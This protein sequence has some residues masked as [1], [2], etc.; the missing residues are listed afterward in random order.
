MLKSG[1]A[2]S[3]CGRQCR[4]PG[5]AALAGLPG[6]PS[7]PLRGRGQACLNRAGMGGGQARSACGRQCR[8][9]GDAALAGL[10]GPLPCWCGRASPERQAMCLGRKCPEPIVAIA[11]LPPYSALMLAMC[12]M[13]GNSSAC[14]R[15]SVSDMPALW[16]LATRNATMSGNCAISHGAESTNM[17]RGMATCSACLAGSMKRSRGSRGVDNRPAGRIVMSIRHD[18]PSNATP[19]SE[20]GAPHHF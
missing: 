14:R 11:G 8:G 4:G 2:Q 6:P 3:A 12:D 5:D 7:S 17:G 1:Q 10:P 18:N 9:P 19:G 20:Q 13:W 16:F 15:S